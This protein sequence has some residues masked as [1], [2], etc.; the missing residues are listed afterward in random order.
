[1][2]LKDAEQQ[3]DDAAHLAYL[4]EM[5]FLRSLHDDDLNRGPVSGPSRPESLGGGAPGSGH[6]RLVGDDE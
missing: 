6:L 3:A 2:K 4:E 5:D 1:M